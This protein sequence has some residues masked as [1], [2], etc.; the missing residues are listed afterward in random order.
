[1]AQSKIINIDMV[2]ASGTAYHSSSPYRIW[3]YTKFADGR[4][5]AWINMDDSTSSS[6]HEFSGYFPTEFSFV[7]TPALVA[8]GYIAAN[9]NS[10]V[11]YTSVSTTIYDIYV[12]GDINGASSVYVFVIGR[13]K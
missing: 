8:S 4:L 11:K 7:S 10:G 2:V 1:M 12:T 6:R 9:V 13:W 3:N 5:E